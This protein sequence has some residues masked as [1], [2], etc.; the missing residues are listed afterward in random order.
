MDE[1]LRK[2][3]KLQT[4]LRQTG[5]VT[6]AFSAGVDSTF[7]LDTARRTLGSRVLAV[8]ADS[9]FFTRAELQA[10]KDLCASLGVRHRVIE[11]PVLSD[12]QIVR[13]PPDRCY[14]CKRRI[15]AAVL[16]SA[17]TEGL[18]IVAEGSNADDCGDYR[19]GRRALEE[20]GV[21]SP[22]LEAGLGKAEIRTL[23]RMAGLPTWDKPSMACLASRLVY[24]ET[25][26]AERL[27]RVG[28]AEAWLRE[29]GLRQVRVRLHGDLARIE[30]DDDA[31]GKL[32]DVSMLR[33]INSTLRA[34]GFA[35][36]TLDL[37]GYQT[38]SMN[39]TIH[40][41]TE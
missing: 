16:E 38:G 37:G 31:W 1:L 35:Y 26:T 36:V 15:M 39:R 41:T 13:N 22:L 4:I 33:E 25:I 6:V 30:A 28:Q 3:E 29:I 12:P 17:H 20:L 24:G 5:G 11:I 21:R 34:M 7:L 23:S 2:Y 14:L 10:A 19:P 32:L 27:S 8:T 9:A 18:P 40:K